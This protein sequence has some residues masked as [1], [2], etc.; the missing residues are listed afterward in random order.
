VT[1]VMAVRNGERFL[2]EAFASIF[3]STRRPLEILLVDGRSTDRTTEIAADTPLTRV[4]AQQGQGI[5]DAY[6][7]GIAHAKGDA[8]A[9]LSHDDLWADGKLDRQLAVM[10]ADPSLMLTVGMVRH[11][12]IG[13]PPPG[14][15]VDL[16][17]RD[18]PG[19]I[20]ET[21]I[22]RREAFALVG[23]FDTTLVTAEDVDWFARVRQAALN[24]ALLPE[25][26][27]TK[28][29]HGANA[30]LRDA[31]GSQHL[32]QALHSAVRRKGRR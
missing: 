2:K 19:Y 28:R 4:I 29:I 8:I 9:F 27:L 20:M 25:L 11:V 15:R 6:N 18:V 17:G 31:R 12:L 32:L 16:L 26:L 30:S 3:R 1:V 24:S 22:A 14:F 13:E 10:E 5:A 23:G 7:L 21:L